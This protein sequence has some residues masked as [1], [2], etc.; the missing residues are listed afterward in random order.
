MTSELTLSEK[1]RVNAAVHGAVYLSLSRSEALALAK[2]LDE[3]EALSRMQDA[4]LINLAEAH[5]LRWS[6]KKLV[7]RWE[8][9]MWAMTLAGAAGYGAHGL[10]SAF[11]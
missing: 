5:A 10:I 6:R 1:L 8:A 11:F 2:C 7:G 4:A 9:I 3:R